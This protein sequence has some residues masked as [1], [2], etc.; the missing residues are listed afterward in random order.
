MA[1][2][3]FINYR[4]DDG[5]KNS[6][7]AINIADKLAQAFGKADVFIDVETLKPGANFPIILA[8]ALAECKVMIVVIGPH[9]LDIRS[10]DNPN[11]RRLNDPNDWVRMEI[12]EALKRKIIVIPVLIG[13]AQMPPKPE[14]PVAL[15]DLSDRQA[16]KIDPTN[17]SYIMRGL[18]Q[19][20]RKILASQPP[21]IPPEFPVVPVSL[22]FAACVALVGLAIYKYPGA[23]RPLR[24]MPSAEVVVKPLVGATT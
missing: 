18:V 5:G 20:I 10:D 21:E 11:Q 16:I 14:L 22:G 13:G 3:I 6:V 2:A 12:A 9:W 7:N 23:G 8:K 24:Q 4:R 17:L 1:Q 19:D 15:R